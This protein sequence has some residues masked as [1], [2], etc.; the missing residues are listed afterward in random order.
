MDKDGSCC[1]HC[2]LCTW[3]DGPACIVAIVREKRVKGVL[4]KHFVGGWGGRYKVLDSIFPR[5]RRLRREGFC[6]F[7]S[8]TKIFFKFNN[9]II[10]KGILGFIHTSP[11]LTNRS[12]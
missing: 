1:V 2:L 4:G 3:G 10:K 12:S 9:R 11:P 7:N 5:A 6:M 8:N